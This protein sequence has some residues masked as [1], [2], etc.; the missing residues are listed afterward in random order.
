MPL[1]FNPTTGKLDLV[2]AVGAGGGQV[3][4]VVAGTGIS[5]DSSD[6]A[7]PVVTNTESQVVYTLLL[8]YPNTY[9]YFDF[10][11]DSYV[12]D[13]I[14]GWKGFF[15]K[16]LQNVP[17]SQIPS[18]NAYWTN[19]GVW[20]AGIGSDKDNP[21][22]FGTNNEDVLLVDASIFGG[23]NESFVVI[24]ETTPTN[25]KIPKRIKG[26]TR[27]YVALRNISYGGGQ[28]SLPSFNDEVGLVIAT[29][30]FAELYGD[31]IS[32]IPTW[33][34]SQVN[35]THGAQYDL[36]G[37]YD[38]SEGSELRYTNSQDEYNHLTQGLNADMFHT[39]DSSGG[40]TN[41]D[42]GAWDSVYLI[43]Q[44]LDGGTL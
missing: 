37:G 43:S 36:R 17:A 8:T 27:V 28:Y 9:P 6:P 20:D 30:K 15:W 21:Y 16:A 1:K 32:G 26:N 2:N 7:N 25:S 40:L 22:I 42:G 3:D 19:I 10:Y 44:H 11:Y 41:L 18:E 13:N 29:N 38:E 31:T 39:H 23:W 33:Y 12:T 35:M 5:V 14:V 24:N 34:T 4:S